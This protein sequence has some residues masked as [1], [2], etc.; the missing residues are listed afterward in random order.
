MSIPLYVYL[1]NLEN[2]D[3]HKIRDEL[4]DRFEDC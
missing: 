3:H 2:F 4:K 1:V